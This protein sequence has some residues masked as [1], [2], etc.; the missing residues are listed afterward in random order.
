MVEEFAHPIDEGDITLGEILN[1]TSLWKYF[2]N[3]EF[4]LVHKL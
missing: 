1:C 2:G 4:E 3:D